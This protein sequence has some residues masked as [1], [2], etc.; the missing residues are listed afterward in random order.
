[1][2]VILQF[3]G[4]S[5]EAAHQAAQIFSGLLFVL[6]VGASISMSVVAVRRLRSQQQTVDAIEEMM[7]LRRW[8]PAGILLDRFLS[9]PVRSPRLWASA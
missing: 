2:V 5:N 3:S 1:M 6:M 4:R 9:Q 8:E 7:Q